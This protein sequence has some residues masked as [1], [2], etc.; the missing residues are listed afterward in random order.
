MKISPVALAL[1]LLLFCPIVAT[2]WADPE[3]MPPQDAAGPSS[4]SSSTSARGGSFSYHAAGPQYVMD[5]D[6]GQYWGVVPPGFRE[7]DGKPHSLSLYSIAASRRGVP[8]GPLITPGINVQDSEP[9]ALES[10]PV[11]ELPAGFQL[12]PSSPSRRHELTC[13]LSVLCLS[14]RLYLYSVL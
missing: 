2:G 10:S 8:P 9:V 3:P 5:Y 13:C 12:F 1:A 4:S 7:K 14:T 6:E 11:S